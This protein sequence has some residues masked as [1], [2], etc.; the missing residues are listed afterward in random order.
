MP[1]AL[2]LTRGWLLRYE[3]RL[4][5]KVQNGKTIKKIVNF[6]RNYRRRLLT[7]RKVSYLQAQLPDDGSGALRVWRVRGEDEAGSGATLAEV[8]RPQ[9]AVFYDQDCYIALYTYHAPTGDQSILYYWM[10]SR[11]PSRSMR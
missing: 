10:V 8:E 2:L 6:N 5:G 11:L 9:A 4:S 3:K 1:S 7:N